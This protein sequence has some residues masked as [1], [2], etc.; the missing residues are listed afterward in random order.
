MDKIIF[1]LKDIKIDWSKVK[2]IEPVVDW[3]NSL[4]RESENIITDLS[5]TRMRLKQIYDSTTD[6]K[7]QK[8][9][10]RTCNDLKILMNY[11]YGKSNKR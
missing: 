5:C 1:D 6:R 2:P 10:L 4:N 7:M 3:S 11:Y 9:L 8:I